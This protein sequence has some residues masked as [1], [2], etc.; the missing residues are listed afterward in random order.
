MTFSNKHSFSNYEVR[1]Y[2]FEFFS[3]NCTL[4][5]ELDLS[6]LTL[7]SET[8]LCEGQRRRNCPTVVCPGLPCSAYTICGF[9]LLTSDTINHNFN[10]GRFLRTLEF[11]SDRCSGPALVLHAAMGRAQEPTGKL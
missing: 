7:G 9:S 4:W 1:G 11:E 5:G 10:S 2:T 6:N 3:F 8:G